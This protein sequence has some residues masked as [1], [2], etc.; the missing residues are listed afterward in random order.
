MK[1][2]KQKYSAI[3]I[4]IIIIL[5][6]SLCFGCVKDDQIGGLENE[7][8]YPIE[9][10]DDLGYQVIF[11]KAPQKI[12]SL[13]PSNTEIIFDLGLGEKV[14]GVSLYCNF[15]EEA[16]DIPQVGFYTNPD[17]ESILRLEPDVVFTYLDMPARAREQLENSDIKVVSF[18][19]RDVDDVINNIETAGKICNV[20]EKTKEVI[21]DMEYRRSL[22]LD[23]VENL[24]PKRVFMDLGEYYT[25]GSQSFI[26]EM[27]TEINA[28]NI[29]GYANAQWP[30][31]KESKIVELDPQVY[32]A[33]DSSFEPSFELQKTEAIKNNRLVVFDA[34]SPQ[35]DVIQRPGPRI[36]EA[37]EL[38][39]KII[40]PE[41]FA[42]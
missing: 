17:V 42:D 15:P 2:S 20:Q 9:I 21:K 36:I 34:Q 38:L 6:L 12:V 27:L 16:K 10:T 28:M 29:A 22:L 7:V 32:I 33:L 19:P 24:E 18:N 14:V 13:A 25:V 8:K 26:H 39:S 31:L 11:E 30:Q 37:M 1:P 23:K 35:S 41:S 4:G 5:F 3:F 40:Y